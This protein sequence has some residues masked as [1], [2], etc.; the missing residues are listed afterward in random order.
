MPNLVEISRIAENDPHWFP[1][2]DWW[3]HAHELPVLFLV[4][5]GRVTYLYQIWCN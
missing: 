1:T 4:T 2:F 3:R 5:C